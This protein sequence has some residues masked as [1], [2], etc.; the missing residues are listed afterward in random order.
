MKTR[1]RRREGDARASDAQN[2]GL[3]P[4]DDS[5]NMVGRYMPSQ[6]AIAAALGLSQSTVSR[7][8]RG[9][10]LI[11]P[12]VRDFVRQQARTL[13][14]RANPHIASLMAHIRTCRP[15]PERGCIALII[16][17]AARADALQLQ[18]YREQYEGMTTRARE[19]GFS[20][21]DFCLRAPGLGARRLAR[22]LDTR[23]IQGVVFFPPCTGGDLQAGTMDWSHYSCA[24]I[25][26]TWKHPPMDRV[27]TD[28]HSDVDEV[29][30]ALLNRG[31]R[32]IGMVLSPR[33][34]ELSLDSVV[35]CREERF[36][37]WQQ[38]MPARSRISLFP[39]EPGL[40]PV[41]EFKRWLARW[42]PD[43][44]V[45][46]LG[47]EK[48]WLDELGVKIPDDL[49]FV[50]LNRPIGGALSGMEENHRVIGATTVDLVVGRIINNDFGPP[51]HPR[52]LLIRSRWTEGKTLASILVPVP[53]N[54][55]SHASR[56]CRRYPPGDT[57]AT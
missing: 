55:E 22:I 6:R 4:D 36:R 11:S 33:M 46:V 9:D 45:S 43:V 35:S 56:N 8:L 25:G 53:E 12:E 3:S 24:T 15:V 18:T 37:L 57:P 54:K 7:A 2:R 29:M 23:G 13:G 21:A 40:A 38:R 19:L 27:R 17:A 26:A 16:D 30:H 39:G 49:G 44:V 52:L 47:K 1:P 31:Y 42:R 41:T 5:K 34:T 51:E 48:I 28:Y 10:P 32:R 20:T 50:C 14:Y